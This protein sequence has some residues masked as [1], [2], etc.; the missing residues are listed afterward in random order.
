MGVVFTGFSAPDRP[1]GGSTWMLEAAQKTFDS[2]YGPGHRGRILDRNGE[3]LATNIPC[4]RWSW[5][6][7]LKNRKRGGDCRADG[8]CQRRTCSGLK[9][10]AIQ[11]LRSGEARPWNCSGSWK[12]VTARDYFHQGTVRTYPNGPLLGHVLGFLARRIPRT[13]VVGV[14][15]IEEAWNPTFTGSTV[16]VIERDQAAKSSLPGQEEAPRHRDEC[17]LTIDRGIRRSWSGTGQ[18][19][20]GS[21]DRTTPPASCWIRQ[22]ARFWR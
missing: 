18:R 22:P 14:R 16:S 1:A 21:S 7:A 10:K 8:H 20:Q 11:V 12:R 6:V 17:Q 3:I 2:H 13:N 19:L 5:M 15:G 9:R 4:A